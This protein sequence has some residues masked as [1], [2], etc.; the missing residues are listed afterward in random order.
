MESQD[1]DRR[2][3]EYIDFLGEVQMALDINVLLT[4]C[5]ILVAPPPQITI[6]GDLSETEKVL[7]ALRVSRSES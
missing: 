4:P 2:Q 6:F 5:L 1:K 3:T 7:K